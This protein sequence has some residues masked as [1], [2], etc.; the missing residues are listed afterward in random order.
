MC[1]A[2]DNPKFGNDTFA[3]L[4][5]AA[6]VYYNYTGDV[7]CFDLADDSDPHDLGGWQWQACTEMIMPTSGNT[8]ESIFPVST[9]SYEGRAQYCQDYYKV[10]PRPTWITT[11]F[12]GHIS[13]AKRIEHDGYNGGGV[14]KNISKSII[15]I[16]EPKGAH[17]VD[18]RF[19]TSKDPKWLR[20]VRKREI[21]IMKD[22]ISEYHH[23]LADSDAQ[24]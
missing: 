10:Q 13:S 5:H 14:L 24:Y 4:Y 17:H 9:Y 21:N 15:A 23:N 7:S 2:I 6:S 3:K 1:K 8:K 11:E 16:V 20:D 18:L 19:S 12:G 22:W